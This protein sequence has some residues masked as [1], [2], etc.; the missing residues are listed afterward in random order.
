MSY[1]NQNVEIVID[2]NGVDDRFGINFHYIEGFDVVIIAQLWDYTDPDV[3][4]QLPFNLGADWSV[5][6]SGYPNTEVVTSVPVPL[7]HKI[8]IFRQNA[9]IQGSSFAEGAFPAQSI[10]DTF[11][12][13]MMVTQENKA[14]LDRALLNPRGGP[15]ITIG[16]LLQ[17]LA[18]I[19]TNAADI[20]TNVLAIAANAASIVVNALA[21]AGNAAL[22]A[23]NNILIGSN[24]SAIGTNAS[25]IATN[26]AN[27]AA[28]TVAIASVSPFTV[29]N[30]TALAAPY[31]ASNKEIVII[32]TGADVEVALPAPT[33]GYQI[34]VKVNN[35]ITN[36]KI[37]NAA[38]IDGFGTDYI[39]SSMYESV[40]FVSDGVKW[41]II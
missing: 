40:S 5:D 3:P 32:D 31:N 34:T 21:I 27:I 8:V 26:A 38:G 20:A 35:D 33:I 18:D 2:G 30:I 9:A 36:K 10:E 15:T 14:K 28:N 23:A 17:A 12:T 24:T 16:D 13:A 37:T 22:I 39:L 19:A 29:V 6:E 1:S 25:D 7:N 11:D 41:Y 4:T